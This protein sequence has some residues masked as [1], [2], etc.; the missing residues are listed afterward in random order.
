MIQNKKD[1][2]EI[3]TTLII[4]KAHQIAHN[5]VQYQNFMLKI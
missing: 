5:Q 2:N 3:I 1:L 4:L